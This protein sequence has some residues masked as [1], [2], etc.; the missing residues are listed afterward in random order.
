LDHTATPPSITPS[1]RPPSEPAASDCERATSGHPV[2][3]NSG[4]GSDQAK[5]SDVSD[6]SA[7]LSVGQIGQVEP[8]VRELEQMRLIDR[9]CGSTRK[10]NGHYGVSPV[11]VFFPDHAITRVN[12]YPPP[13]KTRLVADAFRAM[14]SRNLEK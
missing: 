13:R 9:R 14:R 8:C 5:L 6:L 12:A 10:L 2:I 4:L 11:F 3:A 7:G 1:R